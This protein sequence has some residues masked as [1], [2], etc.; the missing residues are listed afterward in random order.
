MTPL[1][2]KW[3]VGDKV[4]CLQSVDAY[5]SGYGGQPVSHLSPGT[6]AVIA[7][8]VPPVTGRAKYL[9]VVDYEDEGMIRRTSL[10]G[11]NARRLP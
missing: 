11:S 9:L 4:T 10:H 5:Y 6:P 1:T 7:A 2:K 3:H 8:I